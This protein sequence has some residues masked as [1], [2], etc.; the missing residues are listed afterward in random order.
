MKEILLRLNGVTLESQGLPRPPQNLAPLD[1]RRGKTVHF[2]VES[3][4]DGIKAI[5]RF[6]EMRKLVFKPAVV[7]SF[8]GVRCIYVQGHCI[9][10]QEEVSPRQFQCQQG[11]V[12][13]DVLECTGKTF[14]ISAIH[15]FLESKGRKGYCYCYLC[16]CSLVYSLKKDRTFNI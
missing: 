10:Y 4:L 16:C 2:F 11:Q 7:T 13:L 3:A 1:D 12:F 14:L 9:Y 6:I 15:N 5:K 8:P